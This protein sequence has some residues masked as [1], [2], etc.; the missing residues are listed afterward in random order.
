MICQRRRKYLF[1]W[2]DGIYYLGKGVVWLLDQNLDRCSVVKIMSEN[3]SRSSRKFQ[4]KNL[5]D[6]E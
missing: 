5:T 3:L 1:T 4:L 6:E 2:R